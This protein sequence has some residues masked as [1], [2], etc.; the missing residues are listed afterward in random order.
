LI[1][2]K[3]DALYAS[4][5]L[6]QGFNNVS[7]AIFN[8]R[9]KIFVSVAVIIIFIG[10]Y[11]GL[12]A[13][14]NLSLW[15]DSAAISAFIQRFGAW[16]PVFIIATMIIAVVMSPIPSA[17]IA[18]AA[19][20]AYGHAWGA[21]YVLIGAELGALAA[22]GIARYLGFDVM[23]RWFGSRLES[24]LLGS[25]SWLM[26]IVFISRLVPFISF[27]LVSYAAGLTSLSFWRFALATFTGT[28]PSSFLLAHFGGEMSSA[29]PQRIGI[30]V[31]LL[32]AMTLV[33]FG[34]HWFSRQ[35]RNS[36]F[37]KNR[38]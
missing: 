3:H 20:A 12:S 1:P 35:Y 6:P 8:L 37:H 27:D 17:P 13:T 31:I 21:L 9:T 30:A 33:T 38:Q 23:R 26:G 28:I 29:D 10:I 15:V 34:A 4:D 32:G 25:Q 18:L 16:G 5:P 11:W 14:D 7:A 22:Y 24:G 19:G 36:P 2:L